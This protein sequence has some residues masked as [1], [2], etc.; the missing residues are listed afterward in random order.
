MKLPA[1]AMAFAMLATPALAGEQVVKFD[2]PGM[3]CPSCPYIVQSAMQS[4]DGV[5]SVAAD[6][7]TRTA[8]VLFDD[9]VTTI[10]A[11]E[12]ASEQSGYDA[13]LIEDGNS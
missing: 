9:D 3:T 10:E 13:F 4:V 6:F 7:E 2:V 8:I 1:I 5:I 12:L 11:I